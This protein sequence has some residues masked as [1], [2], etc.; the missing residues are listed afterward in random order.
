[1]DIHLWIANRIKISRRHKVI[2]WLFARRDVSACACDG[3]VPRQ[4]AYYVCFESVIDKVR[5]LFRQV[6]CLPCVCECHTIRV[7]FCTWMTCLHS[8]IKFVFALTG[9]K[10]E[11]D[12]HQSANEFVLRV[13]MD[14]NSRIWSVAE[15]W[16]TICIRICVSYFYL[17][18]IACQLEPNNKLFGSNKY[19]IEYSCVGWSVWEVIDTG[20]IS[21]CSI[22]FYFCC[23]FSLI[24]LNLSYVDTWTVRIR[25]R[26]NTD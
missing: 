5:N 22:L 6:A 16:H 10:M 3:Q 26:L 13:Q 8:Y 17:L 12:H 2:Q 18:F 7:S 1:M 9:A 15:E 20:P 21:M 24:S 19:L 23:L 11:Y 4:L 25:R 14:M